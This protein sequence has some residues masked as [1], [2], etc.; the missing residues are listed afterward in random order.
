LSHWLNL[1]DRLVESVFQE[2]LKQYPLNGEGVR[3]QQ[4]RRLRNDVR[5][6]LAVD[7]SRLK[8]MRMITETSFGYPTPAKLQIGTKVLYVHGR[9][10]RIEIAGNKSIIRDLKTARAHPRTDKEAEASP[11]LD[12][13][14]AVY[15]LIA[16]LLA[17]EWQ[18]PEQIEAGYVYLGRPSG[19]RFFGADFQTVLKPA[20]SKWLETVADLL[21]ERQF[22]RTP[23][24]DDCRYCHLQP[25][26][27]DGV[28]NRAALLLSEGSG[29]VAKF[30]ALK[31]APVEES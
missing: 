28:Y 29:A 13:Q 19:E 4:Q 3:A 11:A 22:P 20:A 15:G 8:G 23:N 9:I 31:L 26:C 30:A 21:S 6:L 12:V 7:W 10:D 17:R 18:L 5:D 1:A 25:V 16:E 14:I 2:F 27:G 24:K